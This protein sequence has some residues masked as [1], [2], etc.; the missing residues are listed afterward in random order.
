V[1]RPY[2]AADRAELRRLTLV[3]SPEMSATFDQH[4]WWWLFPTPPMWVIADPQSGQLVG[5]LGYIPFRLYHRGVEYNSAWLV[6]GFV[7]PSHRGQR[8]GV[9]LWSTVSGQFQLAASAGQG[10]AG[11]AAL[12]RLAWGRRIPVRRYIFPFALIP[13]TGKLMQLGHKTCAGLDCETTALTEES[14]FDAEFD[15]LW[16]RVRDALSPLGARD[17]AALRARYAKEP[18]RPYTLLKCR[19]G[20]EL[21]GYLIARFCPR[22]TLT[23]LPGVR[24]GLIVDYLADPQ[25]RE[26][27]ALL[28]REAKHHL[29]RRRAQVLIG[30]TTSQTFHHCLIRA[31][32]LHPDTPLFGW[33]LRR[34]G[35]FLIFKAQGDLVFPETWH[36]TLGDCDSELGWL[37]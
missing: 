21:V 19:R 26:A 27:H 14:A 6:D 11:R 16:A 30:R 31:G 5:F 9:R 12:Q 35:G 2:E 24:V 28:L 29:L 20:G 10:D 8:L 23:P 4:W 32:F 33:A 34:L 1:F 18:S 15:R 22:H 17:A 7:L 36:L 3:R 37:V 13:G 25:D